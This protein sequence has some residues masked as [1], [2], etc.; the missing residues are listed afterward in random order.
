MVLYR[1]EAGPKFRHL[2][3]HTTDAS[4]T[5]LVVVVVPDVRVLVVVVEVVEVVVV[6]PDVIAI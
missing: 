4:P 5:L 6:V 2:N 1:V 3:T